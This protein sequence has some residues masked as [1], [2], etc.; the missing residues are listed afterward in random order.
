MW[1]VKKKKVK[2]EYEVV[3]YTCERQLSTNICAM[4]EN[5]WECVGGVSYMK[6]KTGGNSY[7]YTSTER[8][9]QAMMRKS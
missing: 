5:G 4:L 7:D 2:Y 9:S 1:F 3:W 6:T 8:Y